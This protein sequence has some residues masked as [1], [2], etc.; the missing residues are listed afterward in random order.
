MLNKDK[1]LQSNTIN[2]CHPML[3]IEFL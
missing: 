1:V 2:F 3:C